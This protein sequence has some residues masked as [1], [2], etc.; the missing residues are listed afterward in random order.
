MGQVG[1][2]PT[3]IRLRADCSA[4][5]LLTQAQFTEEGLRRQDLFSQIH[6]KFIFLLEKIH[7]NL[8]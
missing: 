7:L 3:T 4:P 8:L 6:K 2:E 1:I 5:E